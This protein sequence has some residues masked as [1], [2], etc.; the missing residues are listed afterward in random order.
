MTNEPLN[1]NLPNQLVC[2]G[3]SDHFDRQRLAVL[4]L[5]VRF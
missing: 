4:H 3:E 1:P 2:F 5:M